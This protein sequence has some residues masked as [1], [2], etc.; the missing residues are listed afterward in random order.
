MSALDTYVIADRAI[1]FTSVL[2]L[3]N[4]CVVRRA[5]RE[6]FDRAAL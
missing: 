1:E 2:I 6:S 5:Y 4:I 3:D